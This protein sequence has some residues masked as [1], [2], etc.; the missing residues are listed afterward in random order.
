MRLALTGQQH[1]DALVGYYRG[2]IDRFNDERSEWALHY[3][4]LKASASNK[5]SLQQELDRS[6]HRINQ[7]ES[8]LNTTKAALNT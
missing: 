3:E 4:Q 6:R 5:Y 1:L 7:L 2:E 8:G